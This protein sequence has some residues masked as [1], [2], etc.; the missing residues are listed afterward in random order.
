MIILPNAKINIGLNI[1]RKRDDG[2]H[3][4]QTIF[5]PVELYDA[6]EIA[7]YQGPEEYFFTTSG[8]EI[9]SPP[10][11]NLVI[12]ALRLVKKYYKIP[13]LRIHLHKNIP[14]GA[15]LGGGS[16]DAAFMI[17]ILD[18]YFNL[19]IPHKEQLALAAEICA[20]CAFFIDHAPSYATGIGDKL[21]RVRL[22]LGKY[23]I[24]IEKPDVNIN[25]SEIYKKITPNENVPDLR[26]LINLPIEEWKNHI[27]ND[28]EKIVFQDYPQ[29]AQLKQKFYEQGAI[30]ASMTG[31]GSAVFGIFKPID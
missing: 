15:G 28:F 11:S 20:D 14:L 24:K 12:K 3:D 25:T 9:D 30:Y 23:E 29:V 31:S 16:A 27:F 26:E 17:K 5:Y 4:L 10:E 2:Y 18:Y 6:L 8:Y 19:H 1:L 21:Q 22:S 7:E 13:P